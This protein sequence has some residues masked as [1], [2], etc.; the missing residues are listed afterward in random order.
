M[1]HNSFFLIKV[2][3]KNRV[4]IPL[5]YRKLLQL[6]PGISVKAQ[7]QNGMIILERIP[8]YHLRKSRKFKVHVSKFLGMDVV[9]E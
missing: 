6:E 9:T 1:T 8:N 5:R 4:V 2:D 7:Y 3:Q